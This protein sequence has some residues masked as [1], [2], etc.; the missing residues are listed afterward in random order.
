[1][2]AVRHPISSGLFNKDENYVRGIEAAV[3]ELYEREFAEQCHTP[4]Y[5]LR[6]R[7]DYPEPCKESLLFKTHLL[8]PNRLEQQ[9]GGARRAKSAYEKTRRQN[10]AIPP[11]SFYRPTSAH[12]FLQP[13]QQPQQLQQPPPEPAGED[14]YRYGRPTRASILRNQNRIQSAPVAIQ[15]ER[16]QDRLRAER[17]ERK[18]CISANQVQRELAERKSGRVTGETFHAFLVGARYNSSNYIDRRAI[19]RYGMYLPRSNPAECFGRPDRLLTSLDSPFGDGGCGGGGCQPSFA[20]GIGGLSGGGL[21]TSEDNER[22]ASVLSMFS[23]EEAAAEEAEDGES[24]APDTGR[25]LVYSVASER[26]IETV[27]EDDEEAGGDS[28]RDADGNQGVDPKMPLETP[29]PPPPPPSTAGD[30]RRRNLRSGQTVGGFGVVGR[31]FQPPVS[32]QPPA[33]PPTSQQQQQKRSLLNHQQHQQHQQ[34]RDRRRTPPS[35]PRGAASLPAVLGR[36][37]QQP[38]QQQLYQHSGSASGTPRRVVPPM[39]GTYPAHL[40]AQQPQPHQHNPQQQQLQPQQ[41]RSVSFNPTPVSPPRQSPHQPQQAP[42]RVGDSDIERMFAFVETAI[43]ERSS[44]GTGRR[45]VSAGRRQP[46]QPQQLLI[47][48]APSNTP[49]DRR[50]DQS[51]LPLHLEELV[52]VDEDAEKADVAEAVTA[53]ASPGDE[54]DEKLQIKVSLQTPVENSEP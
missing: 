54:A 35:I 30:S 45:A 36:A 18:R 53:A 50:D 34:L 5:A 27:E 6:L 21:V 1:M 20:S 38:P 32:Q 42:F 26:A 17:L 28:K 44:A 23:G 14:S 37:M 24:D 25:R 15:E 10:P 46:Q 4:Q 41:Q 47:G 8:A 11:G 43:A 52:E 40:L 29:P 51:A 33:T 2:E 9:D 49:R 22:L 7:Q 48:Q 3:E 31:S 12:P 16:R 19:D 13:Q 39:P